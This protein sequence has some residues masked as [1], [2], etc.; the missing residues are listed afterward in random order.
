MTKV[1]LWGGT[2]QAELIHAMLIESGHEVAHIF[3]A[4]IERPSFETNAPFSN[5]KNDLP[6]LIEACDHFSV[7]IGRDY[8]KA[9]Y[10]IYKE[11]CKL[12]VKPIESI[13][14]SAIIDTKGEIG[15]M[16]QVMPGAV[17]H[18][19]VTLGD[20]VILNCN[21]TLDHGVTIGNGAHIMLAASLPGSVNVG[22][23]ATVGTNATILPG[24]NIGEGA[25]V[26]AGAV[27]VKDVAPY[28]VV[29]GTP[30]KFLRKTEQKYDLSPFDVFK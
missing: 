17:V 4:G 14:N 8:G 11:L 21:T 18:K 28:E 13:H 12:G 30:A 15:G 10:L 2:S 22:D 6:D 9:R 1:L 16:L 25:F 19:F 7:C 29:V 27:V 26:G 5:N 24:I 3:D 20:A 23:Y